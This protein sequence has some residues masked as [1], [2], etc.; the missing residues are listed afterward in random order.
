MPINPPYRLDPL[1]MPVNVNWQGRAYVMLSIRGVLSKFNPATGDLIWR[2]GIPLISGSEA[3]NAFSFPACAIDS[4]GCVY[5]LAAQLSGGAGDGNGF[6]VQKVSADG[7]HSLW[8]Y[9]NNESNQWIYM[10]IDADDNLYFTK[11]FYNDSN[12]IQGT[13]IQL[14]S[15][16]GSEMGRR[17]FIPFGGDPGSGGG[18]N[19]SNL[20]FTPDASCTSPK[21]A[22]IM[23]GVGQGMFSEDGGFAELGM[24][25][26]VFAETWTATME[27][28][29]GDASNASSGT[30]GGTDAEGYAYIS[31]ERYTD[32]IGDDGSF[33][34][35]MSHA[36]QGK[37]SPDGGM[38]LIRDYGDGRITNAV[39]VTSKGDNYVWSGVWSGGSP[40]P[41]FLQLLSTDGA[42]KWSVISTDTPG[43]SDYGIADED[44]YIFCDSGPGTIKKLSA[45]DGTTILWS[46]PHLLPDEG[47]QGIPAFGRPQYKPKHP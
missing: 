38:S 37:F 27:G 13:V 1:Q 31:L 29:G 45:K 9:S 4:H 20:S 11:G 2:C 25:C 10:G 3:V 23:G 36:W 34:G 14:S 41:A 43:P 6:R 7:K 40:G 28:L 30:L 24:V 42:V 21:G 19:G 46:N 16:D 26:S 35:A 22:V 32:I 39:D 15:H 12:V 17:S 44:G 8:I 33:V 18:I 5:V 47:D